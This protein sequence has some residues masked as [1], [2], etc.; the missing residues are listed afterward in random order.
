MPPHPACEVVVAIPVR[1][2]A[3]ELT[4]A[5][6][7]LAC[8]VDQEGRRLDSSRYEV[9]LLANNCSD[10][11]ASL[12]RRL[13]RTASGLRLH[14]ADVQLPPEWAHVGTARRLAMDAA[15]K[16]ISAANRPYGIIASTDADS[17]VAPDWI[18][19]LLEAFREGADAVGGR[20]LT[21]PVQR[22]TLPPDVRWLYLLDVAYR[23]LCAECE[24]Y[25]DPC[26]H[27]PRP[28]HHQFQG[29]NMAVTALAYQRAGRLP[30]LPVEE[31]V[32]LKDALAWTGARIRHSPDVRVFTSARCQGRALGGMATQLETWSLASQCAQSEAELYKVAS[33]A[34]VC[35]RFVQRR[36]LRARWAAAQQQARDNPYVRGKPGAAYSAK[37]ALPYSFAQFYSGLEATKPAMERVDIREAIRALRLCLQVLRRT[38]P[39]PPPEEIQ[40]VPI[41]A[42]AVEMAQRRTVAA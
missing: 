8:Q 24:A 10:G 31:D 38:G 37:Q 41:L 1:N 29:A 28:R 20:V 15:Y 13:A 18:A 40:P 42:S 23:L 7:A 21:D 9:V 36:L 2:E 6:S 16:R 3:R 32:A 27:D 14:V 5:L 19:S 12:A 22:A 25:L 11:S 39:L 17:Q 33:A 35:G 4:K 30:V 26:L 34:E